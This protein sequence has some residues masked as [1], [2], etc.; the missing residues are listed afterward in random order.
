MKR[1]LRVNQVAE[2]MSVSRVT[3]WRQ[4]KSGNFPKPI[5][6]SMGVTVWDIRDIDKFMDS[7]RGVDKTFVGSESE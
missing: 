7:K 1:Y 4:V 2:Y 6:S 5:K 3:I